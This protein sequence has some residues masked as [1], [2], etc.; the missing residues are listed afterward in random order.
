[1]K[2]HSI[3]IEAAILVLSLT[4]LLLGGCTSPTGNDGE[5]PGIQ[6]VY[7]A[8]DGF[9]AWSPDG[10]KIIYMHYGI[11][12]IYPG[13]MHDIN[14]DLRGLWMINADGSNPHLLLQGWDVYAAWSPDGRWIAFERGKQ[15]YKVPV[16]GD[17]LDKS[18]I[19][20]LTFAGENFYPA[21]SPD[22]EWI[23]YDSNAESPRGAN[24]IWK[25]KADG[26]GKRRIAYAS[27][28]GE[29]R[30][31]N[32]FPDNKMILHI[33]YL[34]NTYS[35]EIFTMDEN[36]GNPLRLTFNNSTDYYP[37]YSSDGRK[38]VF[39]SQSRNG[40]PPQIW[41]MNADGSN[42]QPLTT[43]GGVEPSWSPD[44]TK[45]LF[46]RYDFGKFDPH[47]GTVWVMNADGSNKRQ[48]T[49]GPN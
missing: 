33:R 23:A 12:K 40:G 2:K 17:S 49:Y 24:F 16:M 20:Q 22:G 3:I 30:Q 31:P 41:I 4:V 6:P 18:R 29:T 37:Q 28:E 11:I 45:I 44:G 32:W 35:S 10:S 26:S 7:P 39:E 13:G 25:M 5:P 38:I 19:Q 47:N 1:M 48:L 43:K 14:P 46:C 9:P 15:I 42:P 36:G 21:W 8:I 27:T 34:V